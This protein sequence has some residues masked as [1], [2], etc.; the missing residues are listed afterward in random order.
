LE[1]QFPPP[2]LQCQPTGY[3]LAYETFKTDRIVSLAKDII[4]AGFANCEVKY[5]THFNWMYKVV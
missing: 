1:R 4:S 5:N 2:A 3:I